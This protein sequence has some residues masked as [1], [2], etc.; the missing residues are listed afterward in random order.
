MLAVVLVFGMMVV[1]CDNGSTGSNGSTGDGINRSGSFTAAIFSLSE[2]DYTSVFGRAAPTGFQM[3]TGTRAELI[4]LIEPAK[5]A[6]SFNHLAAGTN[7]TF[8]QVEG[9]VQTELVA[10]SIITD[11][12]R[13]TMMTAVGNNGYGVGVIPIPGNQI[14]I[15]AAYRQQ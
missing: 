12:N 2:S 3:L 14:G 11:A 8:S 7:L 5:A 10:T 1:G 6:D 15:A 4:D 13:N 9:A